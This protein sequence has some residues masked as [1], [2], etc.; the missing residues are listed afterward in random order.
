ML[1]SADYADVIAKEIL[2]ALSLNLTGVIHIGTAPKT[3]FELARR[4]NPD[5]VPESAPAHFPKRK[6]FSLKK[7]E[8]IKKQAR[9][10]A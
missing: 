10:A 4:R 8:E 2:L 9:A 1:S 7:W 5:I 3:L 6:D